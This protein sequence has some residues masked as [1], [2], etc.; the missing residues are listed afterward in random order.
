MC[1]TC[2]IA[3][4]LK[5]AFE[6]Y[7]SVFAL[8]ALSL[9]CAFVF[10]ARLKRKNINIFMCFDFA[11]RFIS[12]CTDLGFPSLTRCTSACI[13]VSVKCMKVVLFFL[14]Q[15]IFMLTVYKWTK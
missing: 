13:S 9:Q 4:L 2:L 10:V 12:V 11:T 8:L 7:I 6:S 5:H 14:K 3:L 15:V 1:K